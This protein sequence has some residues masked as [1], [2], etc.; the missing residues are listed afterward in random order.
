MADER[1]SE[2]YLG[3]E[4]GRFATA[5]DE[6]RLGGESAPPALTEESGTPHFAKGRAP[7]QHTMSTH[8]LSEEERRLRGDAEQTHQGSRGTPRD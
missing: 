5:Q 8:R 2:T 3:S 1:K 6:E 4:E 7:A